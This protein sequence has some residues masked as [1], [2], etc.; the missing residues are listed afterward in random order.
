MFRADDNDKE[1]KCDSIYLAAA[2]YAQGIRLVSALCASGRSNEFAFA[3][4]DG[5]ADVAV[6]NYFN[7][8]TL[9]PPKDVFEALA[10]LKKEADA[11][12]RSPKP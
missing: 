12:R 1:V 4:D 11:A 7:R 10:Q 2:L 5:A 9:L 8:S 6:R 3:N